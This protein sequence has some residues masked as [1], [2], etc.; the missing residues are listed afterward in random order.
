MPHGQR[1]QKVCYQP[2]WPST[3]CAEPL[4]CGRERL[5]ELYRQDNHTFDPGILTEDRRV[6]RPAIQ[7]WPTHIHSAESGMKITRRQFGAASLLLAADAVFGAA[8]SPKADFPIHP[9][10]RIAVA[11]YPFRKSIVAP[12]N[13]DRDTSKP[14]MDLAAFARFIKS[15]FRVNGIEPLDSHFPSK[16]RA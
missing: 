9:R 5:S 14:G 13:G 11:T 1:P 16:E 2:F 7:S 15:K 3:R 4:L 6:Y 12:K 8:D 10:D